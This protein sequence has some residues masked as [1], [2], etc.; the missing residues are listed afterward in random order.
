MFPE[1]IDL[2]SFPHIKH[3]FQWA[4]EAESN[5]KPHHLVK[6]HKHFSSLFY[7]ARIVLLAL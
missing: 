6:R 2:Y 4:G 3:V 5:G 1:I 7:S